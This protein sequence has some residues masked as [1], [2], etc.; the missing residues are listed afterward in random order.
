MVKDARFETVIEGLPQPGDIKAEPRTDLNPQLT[1]PS[2]PC[3]Q[4]ATE[5]DQPEPAVPSKA[6]RRHA[7]AAF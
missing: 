6:V 1:I 7:R 5:L 2:H 3:S 4:M